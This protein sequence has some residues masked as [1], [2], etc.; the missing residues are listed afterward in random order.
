MTAET[1]PQVLRIELH[2]PVQQQSINQRQT[3]QVHAEHYYRDARV[4]IVKITQISLLTVFILSCV[5][6][7]KDCDSSILWR[8]A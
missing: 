7:I 5:V 4:R 2:A 8:A 6:S 1:Q 3:S